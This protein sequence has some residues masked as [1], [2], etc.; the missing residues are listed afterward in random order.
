MRKLMIGLFAT[1]FVVVVAVIAYVYVFGVDHLRQAIETYGGRATK[2]EVRLSGVDLDL[3]AGKVAL[4]GFTQGNPRGYDSPN[5][6]KFGTVTVNVDPHTFDQDVIVIRRVLI[7]GP[8]LTYEFGAGGSNLEAIQR[9]VNEYAGSPASKEP[10]T[11]DGHSKRLIVEDLRITGG[12]V[13]IAA[14]GVRDQKLAATLPDIQLRD[15]GKEGGQ[16]RG[17]TPAEVMEKVV[18]V[19]NQQARRVAGNMDLSGLLAGAAP[20]VQGTIQ[21]LTGRSALPSG[22]EVKSRTEEGLKSL[23]GR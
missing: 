19:L 14:T 11:P 2:A 21:S 22:G 6:V 15:I 4:R 1:I 13:E 16:A 23:I 10:V 12:R 17:A 3:I 9:N 8:Q 18:A 5:A 20:D 7:E